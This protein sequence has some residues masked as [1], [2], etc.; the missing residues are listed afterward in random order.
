MF[1]DLAENIANGSEIEPS[2][3]LE[4][5]VKRTRKKVIV[6]TGKTVEVRDLATRSTSKET[7]ALRP[8]GRTADFVPAVVVN[9]GRDATKRFLTFFSD[10]IRNKNTRQAY[11]RA[12]C[13]FF[14]WCEVNE[15]DFH[16]IESFHVSA[17]VEELLRELSKP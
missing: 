11:H 17:Y 1:G 2:W 15:L 4:L 5:N 14:E 10:N 12:A 6:S 3:Q 9:L 13:R 16:R 8:V 7:K